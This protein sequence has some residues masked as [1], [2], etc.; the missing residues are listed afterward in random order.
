MKILGFTVFLAVALS[1]GAS[2]AL[3][4]QAPVSTS[5]L[6]RLQDSAYDASRDISQLRSRDA[7]LASQLQ[8]E[9]DDARDEIVYL[10]VKLR[11][12]EP[13]ARTEYADLRDRIESL[14][15]R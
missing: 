11:K 6:Q 14:R 4:A 2:G 12:R 9:L 8:T 5:D 13:V 7:A 1:A 3:Y 10:R 15:N